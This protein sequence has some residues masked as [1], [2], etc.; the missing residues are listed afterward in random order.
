MSI[1]L[2]AKVAKP[3]P[4]PGDSRQASTSTPGTHVPTPPRIPGRR[5]PR[6]I[7]LGV[8]ALC[9]G[10]LLSYFVYTRVVTESA[11][12]IMADTVYRGD[13]VEAS[14]LAVTRLSGETA[15]KSI[16][17]SQLRTL[18]GQKA[19][20]DL[21]EGTILVPGGIG[22]V[23]IPADGRAVVGLKLATGRAPAP[24]L[25]PGSHARLVALPGT[26][27]SGQQAS[28]KLAGKTYQASV[29]DQ[30]PGPDGVSV[31]IN[32]EVE[33]GQAPTIAM[34]AASDRIVVVRDPAR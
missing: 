3:A 25:T 26:S 17:A 10:A 33:S 7:A 16:P 27:S 8:V 5:N 19:V 22:E 6:W 20:Y 12:V 4:A 29:I 18:V 21:P 31:L 13:T 32:V 2:Q 23:L 15:A 9:L 28:D 11:V 1:D 14:D 24:L 34:L 30:E